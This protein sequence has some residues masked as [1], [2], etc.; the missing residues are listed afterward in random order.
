MKILIVGATRGVG[1]KLLSLALKNNFEVTVLARNPKKLNVNHANLTVI[2]GDILDASAVA[3]AV[4]GQN[5]VCLCI[6]IPPTGKPVDVFSKGTTNVLAAIGENSETLLLA[7]TGVGA[8]D[9]KGHGGF[10]YDKIINPLLLKS[11]YA[12]KDRQEALIKE[13]DCKWIIVRPAMLSNGA[14]TQKYKIINDLNGVTA[15]K[16][17]REDVADFMLNQLKNPT[18]LHKAPLITY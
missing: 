12:D 17:S 7:V 11:V 16:I 1:E 3:R 4:A 6:G 2:E 10:L 9:S 5:A 8:G 13:S 15:K 18:C 14:I